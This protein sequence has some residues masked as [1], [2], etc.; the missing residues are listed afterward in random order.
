[1][2]SKLQ[3]NAVNYIHLNILKSIEYYRSCIYTVF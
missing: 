1:M 3:N 2:V